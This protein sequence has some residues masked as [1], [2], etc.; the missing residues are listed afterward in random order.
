M[1]KRALL[2]S[3][4]IVSISTVNA[5]NLPSLA[6]PLDIPLILSG[7]F[8]ELRN[9]H[10]HSGLDFK[11]QGRIGFP[12]HSAADGYVS[13]VVVSPWGFGRAVYI[14][15]P[16]LGIT[17]VYGHLDSFSPAIDRRVRDIQYEHEQFSVDLSFKPGEIPVTK[18]ER[19]A[20]SGNAGSSGGPHLHMDVRDTESEDP[21]DP[22]PYFKQHIRDNVAPEVRSIALYPVKG[23]GE[24]DGKNSPEIHAP[25]LF[26]QPFTAWGKV[27]PG[28]KAYDKMS[29]TTN[30]YG[31]KH[32]SLS[33][34]GREVY[35]RT[36]DRVSF[37]TTK[38]VNTLVDYAG[39]VNN[40]SWTMWTRVP[41]SSPLG[42]MIEAENR[43]ILNIAEERDYRCEWTLSDEHGNTTR[44]PFVIKG[45]K[46]PID[47]A[48]VKG[49]R[50]NHD[51][52]NSWSGEGIKVT[53]PTGTFYDDIDFTVNTT[54]SENYLTPIYRI[55]DRTIPISGEYTL[56]IDLPRDTVADKQKY[57]LVRINEKRVTKVDSKYENGTIKG[58]PSAL[59]SFAVTTDTKPPVI[60][61]ELPASWGKKGKVS[62]IISDNLSGIKEWRGEIDGKF[63]LFELDGKTGRLSFRMDSSRFT[64]GK[65]HDVNLIVHDAA[66]NVT[67][68]SGKFTW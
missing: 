2:L 16:E 67:E 14:T 43:G 63:A 29:G 6:K 49:D 52:K 20:T 54:P 32:L 23:E 34:D 33:V 46:Q 37:S 13:R 24:V 47:V 64:K 26:K 11:T 50:F 42:N 5:D 21:L 56:E 10:F 39:V 41:E 68:Y 28:I 30:I 48:P 3:A 1:K 58:T 44:I 65:T 27:I 45:V 38:A 17:T 25:A 36:I 53:F 18:G 51:G 60:K 55:A 9:N 12:V 62:F 57:I 59:G 19:I 8:G 35:R 7:N 66:G 4:F 15:H 31:V 40:G 61:P 22:M